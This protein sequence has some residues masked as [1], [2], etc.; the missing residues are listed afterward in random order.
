M[1]EREELNTTEVMTVLIY[2]ALRIPG[3]LA[4][5]LQASIWYTPWY[6][7]WSRA[8]PVLPGVMSCC[9]EGVVHVG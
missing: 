9:Y 5:I 4:G 7:T 3:I 6:T 2:L 1:I 8:R